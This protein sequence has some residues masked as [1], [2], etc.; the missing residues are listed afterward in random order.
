MIFA[1]G[2]F[3]VFYILTK[4]RRFDFYSVA[5][6]SCLVYFSPSFFGYVWYKAPVIGGG[7][8]DI[9]IDLDQRVMMAHALVLSILTLGMIIYDYTHGKIKENT[10]VEKRYYTE[11]FVTFSVVSYCIFLFYDFSSAIQGNK[12]LFGRWYSVA[13]ISIPFSMTLCVVSK[14]Y[15]YASIVFLITMFDMYIG[16]REAIVFSAL[17]ITIVML[18]MKGRGRLLKYY[19]YMIFGFISIASALLYKNISAAVLSGDW[20]TAINRLGSYRYYFETLSKSEPFVT[21]SILN[22]A[23]VLDWSY[24]GSFFIPLLASIIPFGDIVVG[25]TGTVSGHINGV[26]FEDVGYGVASNIWAESYIYGGWILLTIYAVVYAIIPSILNG[27]M[28]KVNNYHQYVLISIIGVILLFYIQ[29]SGLDSAINLTKRLL[30]FYIL[31]SFVSL[32]LTSLTNSV[33][34]SGQYEGLPRHNR[35]G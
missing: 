9:F 15:F 16:N 20:E 29:R 23:I 5:V 13:A 35:I 17:S 7:Y 22:Y 33:K 34:G 3:A 19:K 10:L 1:I 27:L 2:I 26:L 32:I 8:E 31:C 21:Q 4:R 30:F 24:D 18:W 12:E 11:I 28:T 6:L 14:R 25:N